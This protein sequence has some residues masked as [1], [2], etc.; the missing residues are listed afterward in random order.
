V[1]HLLIPAC[2]LA[3]SLA[4]APPE[5][6]I[7]NGA[8]SARF[9]LPDRNDGYYQGT[10]FDWSGVIASLRYKGHEYFGQWFEKYDPKTHDAISGPV[11]EYRT[12]GAGLGYEEAKAGEGFIRI[13]VGVVRKP[14]EAGYRGFNTYEIMDHGKWTVRNGPDWI[15]FVHELAGVNGYAYEYRKTVRLE[16]DKPVM[17]L[18]H[19]LRNTGR[20]AIET[21]MYN[22]NFFVM[23]GQPTGPDSIVR[24]PF[25]GRPTKD[26]K[27][28]AEVREDRLV[29]LRE[30]AKGESVFTEIGGFGDT[31]RDYD[32]RLENR[33]A[34]MGVRITGDRPLAKLVYWSIRTTF[35]PEPYIN[36][37]VAPG[38]ET[39]WTIGYEFYT[40]PGR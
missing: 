15:E 20:K 4:A 24:L 21:A 34:G 6:S 5:A 29:Y 12:N 31:A 13:G 17:T 14:E 22:H 25:A 2:A 36:L 33:K 18:D 8:I 32:F 16:K 9:Y 19:V 26:L 39:K 35:C 40:L 23:D 11:E 1:R 7:S 10:R 30:L 37:S 27:D 38:G 28:L 3:V